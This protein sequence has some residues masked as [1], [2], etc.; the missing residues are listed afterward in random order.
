MNFVVS[1]LLAY[2]IDRLV[3]S[4]MIPEPVTWIVWLETLAAVVMEA[5]T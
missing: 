5:L 1:M 4:H 3:C 2:Q